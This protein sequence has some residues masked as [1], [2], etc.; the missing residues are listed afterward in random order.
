MAKKRGRKKKRRSL[1]SHAIQRGRKPHRANKR[2]LWLL[3]NRKE[4][5]DNR[6]AKTTLSTLNLAGGGQIQIRSEPTRAVL[7][8]P[9][10]TAYSPF[11]QSPVQAANKRNTRLL[12][13]RQKICRA[14]KTRRESLFARGTAGKGKRGPQVRKLTEHSKVRC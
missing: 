13:E 11:R 8:R 14:R 5:K 2:K 1:K 4:R 3:K 9:G 10:R 12:E 7:V 6:Y